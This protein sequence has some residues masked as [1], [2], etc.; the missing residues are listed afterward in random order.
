MNK[1]GRH[2]PIRIY[3]FVF[4]VLML[5]T[6]ID[7]YALDTSRTPIQKTPRTNSVVTKTTFDRSQWGLNNKEWSR[8]QTLL[9]GIRGSLSPTTLSPL[10][11]LGVHARNDKER[12]KYARKWATMMRD[13]VAKTLAF[14]R[15][16]D[17]AWQELNPSGQIVDLADR[18]KRSEDRIRTGDRLL[19][20][21]RLN[22]CVACPALLSR[23][24]RVAEKYAV[25]LDLYFVDT[26]P[27]KHNVA[28][29]RWAARQSFNPNRVK[30]GLT[31]FNH[32]QGTLARMSGG[33]GARIPSLY[34]IRDDRISRVEGQLTGL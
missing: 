28:I 19:L 33:L 22:N 29:K 34:R 24:Q 1:S 17:T 25:Q 15:A 20:F 13:D 16:Y 2:Y 30:Q 8:Y 27:K 32:N 18:Q 11:V 7:A 6:V 14:Q 10:E 23:I 9:K 12:M 31:T 26:Q 21:L 5:Y 4:G 3:G